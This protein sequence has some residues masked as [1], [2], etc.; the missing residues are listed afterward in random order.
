VEDKMNVTITSRKFKARENL[1][2]YITDEAL[3]LEKFFDN[4]QDVEVILSF[5]ESKEMLKIAEIVVKVPGHV[6]SATEESEEFEKSV[7]LAVEKLE[8]QLK[9]LKT[10]IN[11]RI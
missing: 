7:H 11:E 1:K 5:Q 6:L 4:I 10:K 8:R 2:S 9:K 3:S